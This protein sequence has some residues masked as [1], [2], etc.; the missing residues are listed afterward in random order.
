VLCLYID[1]SS[2]ATRPQRKSLNYKDGETTSQIVFSV[3]ANPGIWSLSE[4]I[5]KDKDGGELLISAPQIPDLEL[6][7][8]YI[9]N[10]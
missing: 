5:I 4:V 7:E 6:Y 2:V 8:L 9:T 3:K 1:S 10:I